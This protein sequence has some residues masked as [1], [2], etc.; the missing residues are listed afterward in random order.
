MRGELRPNILQQSLNK[1][2]LKQLIR[3]ARQL[4]QRSQLV[5]LEANINKVLNGLVDTEDIYSEDKIIRCAAI[6]ACKNIFKVESN[7]QNVNSEVILSDILNFPDLNTPLLRLYNNLLDAEILRTRLAILYLYRAVRDD[8]FMR[9]T[10]KEFFQKINNFC[11]EAARWEVHK[12]VMSL[13]P[14][15]LTNLY[16]SL[17]HT[18][19]A[20]LTSCNTIED[21]FMDFVYE[22]K[23]EYPSQDEESKYNQECKKKTDIAIIPQE[24]PEPHQTGESDKPIRIKDKADIFLENVEEFNFMEMPTIKVLSTPDKVHR[25]VLTMLD[26]PSHACAML[27]YLGF[28]NWIKDKQRTKFTKNQYDTLCSRIVMGM[29]NSHAF[30]KVRMSLNPKNKAA[31]SYQA[32]EYVGQV[33]REYNTL[34]NN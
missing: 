6:N 16:F 5:E 18:Y 14:I 19:I 29:E 22:W 34:L 7:F 26:N 24:I 31:A 2:E 17:Y 23:R 27:E 32:Y 1:D 13:I 10:L 30:H 11:K 3:D 15:K 33:E 12:D 8:V 4:T 20:I 28:Y 21:D 9:A 25:L